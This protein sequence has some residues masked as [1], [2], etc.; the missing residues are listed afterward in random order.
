MEDLYN[1]RE[2]LYRAAADIVVD[3][4]GHTPE[5][6]VEYILEQVDFI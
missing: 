6:C 5:E 1:E 4:A 3:T 2:P